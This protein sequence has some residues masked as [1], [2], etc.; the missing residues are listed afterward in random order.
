MRVPRPS[1]VL[2]PNRP[3]LQTADDDQIQGLLRQSHVVW[4]WGMSLEDYL[5]LWRRVRATPFARRRAAFLAWVAPDGTVLSS[6]KRYRVPARIDGEY[7]T[8]SFLAA[9]FTPPRFRRRG[10]AGALITAVLER[11]RDE[12]DRVAVLFSD[13][14]TEFY[15]RL[16]FH[17]LP[18]TEFR[19]KLGRAVRSGS[20]GILLEPMTAADLD[21]VRRAHD[22]SI[23]AGCRLWVERDAEIWGH[24][25]HRSHSFFELLGR[26][27]ARMRCRVA[28]RGGRFFGY[29]IGVEVPGA[30]EVREVGAADGTAAGCTETL[31]AAAAE[32]W[33]RRSRVARGWLD[34]DLVDA[35]PGWRAVHGPRA[36]AVAMVAMLDPGLDPAMLTAAGAVQLGPLDQF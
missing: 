35:L 27:D 16:G 6:L 13:V 25:R 28:R 1:A 2:S 23:P 31:Q 14:G 17:A 12:G 15:G 36:R 11:A 8:A 18:A 10:H 34:P 19:A 9:V 7:A 5:E 26:A 29:V 33:N 22:A 20:P 4:G 24:L 3:R 30:W 21:D 32:A